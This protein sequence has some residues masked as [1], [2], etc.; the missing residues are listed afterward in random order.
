M[1][2]TIFKSLYDNKALNLRKYI[3]HAVFISKVIK[4]IIC[5]IC[6]ESEFTQRCVIKQPNKREPASNTPKKSEKV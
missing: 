4:S 2:K 3:F 1:G 5:V 6:I